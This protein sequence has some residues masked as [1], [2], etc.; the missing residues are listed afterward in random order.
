MTVHRIGSAVLGRQVSGSEVDWDL[1][2]LR[3]DPLVL[4]GS[5]FRIRNRLRRLAADQILAAVHLAVEGRLVRIVGLG[6]AAVGRVRQE[7]AAAVV[8]D[9]RRL[10]YRIDLAAGG[11]EVVAIE[12]KRKAYYPYGP[13]DRL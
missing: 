10:A 5:G 9:R 3:N 4:V 13:K 2:A 7:T 11:P 6:I 12:L 1:L 8:S